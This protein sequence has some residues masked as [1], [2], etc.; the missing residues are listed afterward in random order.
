MLSP[1]ACPS[2]Y[3]S[4]RLCAPSHAHCVDEATTRTRQVD[5]IPGYIQPH[6]PPP[7]PCLCM[8]PPISDVLLLMLMLLPLRRGP[9]R[10]D[11]LPGRYQIIV[12]SRLIPELMI[13]TPPFLVGMMRRILKFAKQHDHPVETNRATGPRLGTQASATQSYTGWNVRTFDRSDQQFHVE[14]RGAMSC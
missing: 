3:P 14:K 12:C 9:H 2:A 5:K 7:A 6:P 13:R 11:G 10:P 8:S 4:A 1:L